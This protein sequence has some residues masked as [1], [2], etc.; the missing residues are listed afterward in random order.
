[1][2]ATAQ[3]FQHH[4]C[5]LSKS[6]EFLSKVNA[7]RKARLNKQFTEEG[8]LLH[9]FC[10]LIT[11]D[12]KAKKLF[13]LHI[14]P[15]VLLRF[16][17]S[18]FLPVTSKRKRVYKE[19]VIYSSCILVLLCPPLKKP[20]LVF[21]ANCWATLRHHAVCCNVAVGSCCAVELLQDVD[22]LQ[23]WKERHRHC[24]F[25]MSVTVCVSENIM[26]R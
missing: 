2:S 21:P 1:M 18:S 17:I 6:G 22:K 13:C 5:S 8:R 16:T 7:E 23:Y 25:L 20:F 24:L 11:E 19:I 14:L 9:S 26:H 4:V 12:F 10:S 15:R 3:S